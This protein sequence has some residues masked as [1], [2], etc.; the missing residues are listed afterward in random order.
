MKNLVVENAKNAENAEEA[1]CTYY[2]PCLMALT[3]PLNTAVTDCKSC[4]SY[5]S[6]SKSIIL[7]IFR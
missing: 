6:G 2:M 3:K 4:V 1:A 5:N 7:K